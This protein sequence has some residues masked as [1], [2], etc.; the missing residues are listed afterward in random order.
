MDPWCAQ[1]YFISKT[2]VPLVLLTL[3]PS[4]STQRRCYQPQERGTT[5]VLNVLAVFRDA[6]TLSPQHIAL[7]CYTLTRGSR[8]V[9]PKHFLIPSRVSRHVSRPAQYTQHF[10]SFFSLSSTSPS[11]TGSGPRLITSRI[12]CADSRDLTDDGF[13]DPEPRN[14]YEPKKDCRQPD[15]HRAGD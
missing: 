13:A 7:I 10:V 2:S 15:R 14:V 11:F 9:C 1:G 6:D 4:F 5:H 3:L 12:Q 8:I